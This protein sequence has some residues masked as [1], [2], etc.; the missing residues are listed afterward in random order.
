MITPE[1]LKQDLEVCEKAT[2]KI[3]MAQATCPPDREDLYRFEL[4]FG[5]EKIKAYIEEMQIFRSHILELANYEE[6]RPQSFQFRTRHGEWIT[7]KAF[8]RRVLGLE[9]Q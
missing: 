2:P 9:E 8:A 3:G 6:T 5:P 4:H 1:Q 7:P